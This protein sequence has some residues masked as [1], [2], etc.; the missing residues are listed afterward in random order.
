MTSPGAERNQRNNLWMLL[1]VQP[2][3]VVQ[4]A[5]V[6]E[7]PFAFSHLSI[8][9]SSSARKTQ[10]YIVPSSQDFPGTPDQPVELTVV[11]QIGS[12]FKGGRGGNRSL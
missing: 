1:A 12:C 5:L 9:C 10:D 4:R 7:M 6:R 2:L 8:L 11:F 3:L